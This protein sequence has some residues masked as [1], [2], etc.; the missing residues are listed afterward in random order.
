MSLSALVLLLE[1]WSVA[2]EALFD[3]VS[4]RALSDASLVLVTPPKH[5]GSPGFAKLQ[6]RAG[7]VFFDFHQRRFVW[8]DGRFSKLVFPV[9]EPIGSLLDNKGIADA[10]KVE[11]LRLRYESNS[12]SL[13]TPTF[14]DLYKEHALAPFFVLQIF[15]VLLWCLD[16][17]WMYAIMTG[18]MLS[19]MEALNVWKRLKTIRFLRSMIQTAGEVSIN[20]GGK[21]QKLPSSELVPGDL[22]SV[23]SGVIPCDAVLVCGSCVINESTL[24][25]ENVA[26]LKDSIAQ[27]DRDDRLQM[28][29]DRMHILFGGTRVLQQS[30]GVT[31]VA[32][33]T[34]FASSQGRVLRTIVFASQPVSANS[35]EALLFIVFLLAFALV[36][37]GFVLADGLS[38]PDKSP[39]KLLLECIIILTSVVPPELPIEL[40]LAVTASLAALK[41]VRVF[42]T[43][44]FRIPLAGKLD[45]CA[46]DKTGTLTR[47]DLIFCGVADKPT[48]VLEANAKLVSEEALVVVAGC[49][50]L[51]KVEGKV[52]GDPLETAVFERLG[53]K[54]V[55]DKDSVHNA[56]KTNVDI[57]FRY[58][59]SAA[60]RRMT[61]VAIVS[62]SGSRPEYRVCVK[63]APEVIRSLLRRDQQNESFG[64][65]YRH[66]A[67]KGH[68]V[69]ALAS[70]PYPEFAGMEPSSIVRTEVEKDLTFNGFLV[71]ECLLR[72][73]TTA[74]LEQLKA[75]GMISVMITGDSE[76]TAIAVA[77]QTL[78]ATLPPLILKCE[79]DKLFWQSSFGNEE[80][81]FSVSSVGRLRQSHTLCVLGSLLSLFP[82]SCFAHVSVF[83]RCSPAHKE[84]ILV[85]LRSAGFHTLMCGDGTND[86]G[87]LKQAHVGVALV[88]DDS[89]EPV[90]AIAAAAPIDP[91]KKPAR[92]SGVSGASGSRPVAAAPVVV[93]RVTGI[94]I[95]DRIL[96]ASDGVDSSS[97]S[98][99]VG[100]AS[101]AAPF[102]VRAVSIA[103]VLDVIRQGR[104]TL[105]VTLS[106][107]FILAL[108]CLVTAFSLS[109]LHLNG[110][111]FGDA[112]MTTTALFAT[113][114][115]LFISRA[116][117]R[118]TLSP[119][120][121]SARIFSLYFMASLLGQFGV[122]LLSLLAAVHF[123]R[124][125]GE[126]S[127][128]VS[129]TFAPSALNT[130]VFLV[131]FSMMIATFAVNYQGWPHMQ[132]FA[133]NKSLRNTILA[134]SFGACLAL[135]GI[136]NT[137]LSLTPLS[138][139]LRGIVFAIMISDAAGAWIAEKIA[140]LL[141]SKYGKPVAL[142]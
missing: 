122:H 19:L 28:D 72:E 13:P 108:N 121:P 26:L 42:C 113:A 123:S 22:F 73:G 74:V 43:E 89:P 51:S 93:E 47:D 136:L 133:E 6:H 88:F 50:S 53:W 71:F 66:Y 87:A 106:M 80:I 24:T 79:G 138:A 40:A 128:A 46:F 14:R 85:G 77:E 140:S 116:T 21:W 114:A 132:S 78:M 45:V 124:M 130:S 33:R 131:S 32:L 129:D 8:Q 86:V 41:A 94:A 20:R 102:T 95:I 16:E 63:G 83:A 36:A 52:I 4:C 125:F 39:Y 31:A 3:T 10:A 58:H 67:E 110:V 81:P 9:S 49:Q 75:A 101:V 139:Q 111:R 135:F 54:L 11:E 55:S 2:V 60:L 127:A 38:R 84:Q 119:L 126:K 35:V 68:R 7:Q 104:C 105:C 120:K 96:H 115:F 15:F 29:N 48:V 137:A 44:P 59:F 57:V 61:T 141:F 76:L 1:H 92:P 112:Q 82:A 107:Y 109:A 65:V 97:S 34:G 100:D 17:Y 18:V 37:A 5:K 142:K 64:S 30:A 69:I 90:P 62:S 103:P 70:K 27:R 56:R 12:L 25:G 23:S 99:N 91:R 117:P 118:K 98:L 134:G